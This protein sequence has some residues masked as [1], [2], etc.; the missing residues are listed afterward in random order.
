MH[1]VQDYSS[2]QQAM[3]QDQRFVEHAA[4]RQLQA[5]DSASR[6]GMFCTAADAV[7][8][9]TPHANQQMPGSSAECHAADMSE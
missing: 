7:Q 2:C 6:L 1:T 5:T 8:F 9:S 3:Q 4:I